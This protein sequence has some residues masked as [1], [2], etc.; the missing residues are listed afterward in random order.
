M[1]VSM[2]SPNVIWKLLDVLADY[3][4]WKL[5]TY[6]GLLCYLLAAVVFTFF[7]VPT[8]LDKSALTG[9]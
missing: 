4:K 3:K 5:I 6:M 1:Q 8:T 7:I 2:W 9:S